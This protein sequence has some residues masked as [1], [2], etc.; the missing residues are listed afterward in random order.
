MEARVNKLNQTIQGWVNYYILADMHSNCQTTDEWVRRRLRMC[1]WKHWKKISTRLDNLVRL[2][3]SRSKAWEFANTRK[4]YWHIA[5]SPILAS[6]LT[7]DH[8]R[9]LGFS[10][11]SECYTKSL[12]LRTA[13]CR[14]AR[15]VV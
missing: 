13:V 12:S 4:G 15:T 8:F 10:G 7:N 2:G 5:N 14:T 3:I 11:L 9:K 6:S 1:Y